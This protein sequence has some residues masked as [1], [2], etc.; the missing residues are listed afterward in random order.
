MFLA[1]RLKSFMKFLNNL[2]ACPYLTTWLFQLLR[3]SQGPKCTVGPTSLDQPLS[4]H[5]HTVYSV[6]I[7]PQSQAHSYLAGVLF[8]RLAGPAVWWI[9]NLCSS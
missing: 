2:K 5:S 3:E 4:G 6:S 1:R 7:S 9:S 8:S